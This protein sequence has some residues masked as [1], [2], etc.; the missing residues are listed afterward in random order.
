MCW[1]K[2]EM[3]AALVLGASA[4]AAG[5]GAPRTAKAEPSAKVTVQRVRNGGIQP[6]VAV[7]S[8]GV[9]HLITYSGDAGGGDI[10]YIR[11]VD[12]GTTFSEPLQVNHQ[13]GSAIAI[14]SIRGAHLAVGKN[15][16]V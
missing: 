14:G 5:A 6:Q 15:G 3:V 1:T 16:R 9:I 13:P 10:F 7:D 11:S 4:V 12:G 2:R 8:K